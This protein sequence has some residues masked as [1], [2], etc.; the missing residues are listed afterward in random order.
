[1]KKVLK[2][3]GWIVVVFVVLGF[4]EW[5]Q[6]KN[7]IQLFWVFVVLWAMQYIHNARHQELMNRL[8]AMQAKLDSLR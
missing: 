3:L 6:N 4:A 5:L 2:W 8:S 1:M 7:D